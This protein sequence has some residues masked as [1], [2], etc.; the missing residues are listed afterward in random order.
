MTVRYAGMIAAYP[1][2]LHVLGQ[3]RSTRPRRSA[4]AC[5][6]SLAPGS[7]NAHNQQ[8]TKTQRVDQVA[9]L[10]ISVSARSEGRVELDTGSSSAFCPW[11]LAA[12]IGQKNQNTR[13]A[14]ARV[15]PT[16]HRA[17]SSSIPSQRS[18]RRWRRHRARERPA[19]FR[20]GDVHYQGDVGVASTLGS[21]EVTAARVR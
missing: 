18:R 13:R 12:A 1:R 7:R 4:P 6:A 8:A 21:V 2:P 11:R 9:P 15:P 16:A 14:H 19:R 17:N 10:R 20:A 3:R 5:R